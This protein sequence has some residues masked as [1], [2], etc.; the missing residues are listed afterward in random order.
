MN[1][2]VV[3]TYFPSRHANNHYQA[4]HGRVNIVV[5]EKAQPVLLSRSGVAGSSVQ[6]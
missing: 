4:C 1:P 3:A 6:V 5:G 2:E